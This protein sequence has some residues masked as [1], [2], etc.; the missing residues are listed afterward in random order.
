[1]LGTRF[2]ATPEANAHPL[3]KHKL[4]TA[5][6][7]DTVRTDALWAWLAGCP[8]QDLADTICGGVAGPGSARE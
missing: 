4:V 2:L 6:E 1:M 3:Y 7:A 5:S 8:A